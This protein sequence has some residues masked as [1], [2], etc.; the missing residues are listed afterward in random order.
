MM[1]LVLAQ[2][3]TDHW[4]QTS[5]SN[6]PGPSVSS[7]ENES[8]GKNFPW[9]SEQRSIRSQETH[10]AVFTFHLQPCGLEQVN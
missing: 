6:S 5:H 4:P 3:L 1:V 9:D 2:P 8:I 10:A 7:S